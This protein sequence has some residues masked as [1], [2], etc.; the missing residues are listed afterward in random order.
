MLEANT[1]VPFRYHHVGGERI[2][3]GCF[4]IFWWFVPT[5]KHDCCRSCI[6]ILLLVSCL[7]AEALWWAWPVTD[8]LA[9]IGT[10]NRFAA[11]VANAV[12]AAVI[13]GWHDVIIEH[14]VPA[15]Q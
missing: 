12:A 10:C 14:H 2:K 9:L 7:V 13:C 1:A 5:M 3:L 11:A 15:Q 8:L 4:D 6:M